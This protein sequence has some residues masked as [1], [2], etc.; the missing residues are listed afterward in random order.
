[1]TNFDNVW[2]W[3]DSYGGGLVIADSMNEAREKLE[4][5]F[6]EDRDAK[7]TIIWP[8]VKDDYFDKDNPDVLDIY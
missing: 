8:W 3:S 4:R 5:M 1:M 7:Q 6:G 2:R